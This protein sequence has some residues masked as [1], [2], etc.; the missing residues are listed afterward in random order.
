MN[1]FY[2]KKIKIK[3]STANQED[4]DPQ[5][6]TAA[7]S[8]DGIVEMACP[9]FNISWKEEHANRGNTQKERHWP[10]TSSSSHFTLVMLICL[11]QTCTEHALKSS[12]VKCSWC[13]LVFNLMCIRWNVVCV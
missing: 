11:L 5:S 6:S 12:Q 1:V 8:A 10:Y 7:P 13:G 9:S 2:L 4:S 3:K